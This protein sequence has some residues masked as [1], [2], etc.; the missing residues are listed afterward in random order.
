[1]EELVVLSYA[2]KKNLVNSGIVL[3]QL[4]GVPVHDEE[5]TGTVFLGEVVGDKELT[6]SLLWN[7]FFNL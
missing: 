5:G 6:I 3:Q 7:V 1:M 2:C 4:H